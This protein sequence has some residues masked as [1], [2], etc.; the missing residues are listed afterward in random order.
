MKRYIILAAAL[1]A[2]SAAQAQV[3]KCVEGGKTVITDRPCYADSAPTAVK[4]AAGGF[5][6]EEAA[7]ADRRTADLIER[8]TIRDA[9]KARA[10]EQLDARPARASEP[11][12]CDRLRA[13]HAEAARL[14]GEY[15]HPDNIARAQEK[16]KK[17][18][19]D[20]FF[21]CPPGKRVSAFD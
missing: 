4:P 17:A 8:Q 19:Q 7:A 14:A 10:Q 9:A 15:R 16:A 3:Y 2:T 11:D 5:N 13:E 1:L 18:A 6:P 12:E 20:S 21:R